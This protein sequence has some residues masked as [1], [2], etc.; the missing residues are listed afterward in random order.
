MHVKVKEDGRIVQTT[1]NPTV[2]HVSRREVALWHAVKRY[3]TEGK[4]QAIHSFGIPDGERKPDV[5]DKIL[6]GDMQYKDKDGNMQKVESF[7]DFMK[8]LNQNKMRAQLKI[9]VGN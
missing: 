1:R 9:S 8:F 6:Q 4:K 3:D 2:K 7:S 5:E